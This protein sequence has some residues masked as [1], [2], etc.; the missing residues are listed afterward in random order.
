MTITT[1]VHSQAAA[2]SAFD[3]LFLDTGVVLCVA[4]A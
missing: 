1:R 3:V 4:T 2:R